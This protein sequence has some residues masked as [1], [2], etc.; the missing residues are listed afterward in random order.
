MDRLRFGT[1]LAPHHPLGESPTLLLR[2]DLDLAEHLDRLGYDEFW[3]GE[4]HSSGWETIASP[5]M[6]LAA[7]GERTAHDPAR[8]RRR[9]AAL[10]PPV[11]RRPADGPA[12]PHDPRP[13]DVRQRAGRAALRRPHARHR[14]DAHPRPPGRGARR[15]HPP[16][17]AARTASPTSRDWFTLHD[18]AAADPAAAGGHADDRAPRRSARAGCSS[19]ASTASACCRSPRT[20]PRASRPCRRSGASPRRAPRP[21][22]PDGRPRRLAGADGVA[23]RRETRS[24]PGARP[25][26]ACTA[27]TTS[28]TCTSSAGRA[29]S[30]STTRGSCSSRSTDSGAAGRRGGGDRHARRPGR[31]HPP[32]AGAD[33]RLRRRARLRPRLGRPGG[34]GPRAGSWSPA[35]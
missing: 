26:T 5:E 29:P 34:D 13:G 25:S 31:R 12:R 10:P 19:P 4:H 7:A 30:R 8:H 32:P 18:A 2:R 11:Q 14:P 16:A 1:F 33:R 35:T 23:P 21:A 9:L 3:C 28:T 15:D 20:R 22:R 27:G 17:R 24:R 6:F